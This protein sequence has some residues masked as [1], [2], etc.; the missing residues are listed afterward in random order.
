[1]EGIDKTYDDW[2]SFLKVD[3]I[4]SIYQ[5]NIRGVSDVNEFKKWKNSIQLLHRPPSIIVLSEVKLK[6]GKLLYR[7]MLEGYNLVPCLCDTSMSGL[8][9]YVRRSISHKI[10]CKS[11]TALQKI[12]I[13][14]NFNN[15][16]FHLLCFYRP[17]VPENFDSF[18][19]SLKKSLKDCKSH[20]IIV[21]DI[22]IDALSNSLEKETYENILSSFEC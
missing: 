22:N 7:Y 8:M 3:N 10:V 12:V 16:S 20:K 5:L 19:E 17:P 11:S 18:L 15:S 9:V 6:K 21:G 1:M 14:F 2:Q 13:D 4:L